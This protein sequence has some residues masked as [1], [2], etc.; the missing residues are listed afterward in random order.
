[1]KEMRALL[2]YLLKFDGVG[3]D[4]SSFEQVFDV[5]FHP[6]VKLPGKDGSSYDFKAWKEVA[7]KSYQQKMQT[8]IQKTY[9]EEGY[10]YMKMIIRDVDGKASMEQ[11]TKYT[12]QDGKLIKSEPADPSIYDKMAA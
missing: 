10:I 6:D 2:N 11:N 8:D 7:I 9:Q 3:N 1:M 4:V 5:L 12:F